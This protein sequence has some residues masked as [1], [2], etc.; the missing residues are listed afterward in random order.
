MIN[1]AGLIAI[2]WALA[3]ASRASQAAEDYRDLKGISFFGSIAVTVHVANAGDVARPE[4]TTQYLTQFAQR[5]FMES[6]PGIP[7]RNTESSNWS[8]PENL[9]A[10]GRLSCRVWADVGLSP[11]SYQVKCQISTTAHPT[12]IDDGSIGFAPTDK[13]ATVITQ[14]INRIVAGFGTAFAD[15][16]S[17]K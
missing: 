15:A 6:F 12:I 8:R 7:F 16:T 3:F 11:A 4:L 5:R 1:R 14:Q 13:V 9:R 10:M 2:A 17:E